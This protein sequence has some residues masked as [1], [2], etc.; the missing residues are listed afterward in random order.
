MNYY[1]P[2]GIVAMPQSRNFDRGSFLRF[3]QDCNMKSVVV[4]DDLALCSEL[5]IPYPIY[6]SYTFEP[7]PGISPKAN[8]E[9]AVAFITTQPNYQKVYWYINN[10]PDVTLARF[11]MYAFMIKAIANQ[12]LDIKCVFGNFSSGSVRCGQGEDFNEWLTK[13]DA[14]LKALVGTPHVIGV[15]EY[16]VY[17]PW[18]V[19]DGGKYMGV[20]TWKNRPSKVDWSLPQW[21]IGRNMQGI[22]SACKSLNITPPKVIVTEVLIDRMNDIRDLPRELNGYKTYAD[23]WKLQ[24]PEFQLGELYAEFL[25]WSW[26]TIYAKAPV[27]VEA[28]TTFCYGNTGSWQNYNVADDSGYLK[29]MREYRYAPEEDPEPAPA[30]L[31]NPE[32]RII[33]M[34]SDFV[35]QRQEPNVLAHVQTTFVNGETVMY[36]PNSVRNGWVV[37]AKLTG[38]DSGFIGWVSL[39]GGKVTFEPVLIPPPPEEEEVKVI[40]IADYDTLVQHFEVAM[41]HLGIAL[42]IIKEAF[43]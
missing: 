30:D 31:S 19:S 23:R 37:V 15:H 18:Y 5:N 26:E 33:R 6:R 28:I 13:G 32:T 9:A 21:H 40:S 11:D 36:Y 27:P 8:A 1:N 14:F 41:D 38:A 3:V 2:I 7:D 12:K 42:K 35:N 43:E 29:N 16:T 4:L 24:F 22:A 17:Y 39:Q 20:T 34:S 10:E 25:I